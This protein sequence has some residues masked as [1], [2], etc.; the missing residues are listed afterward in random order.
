MDP[1]ANLQEQESILVYHARAI[2][3]GA[4]VSAVGDSD[5]ARLAELRADLRAWLDG[6]GFEPDWA[7]CP[8]AS[9][10]FGH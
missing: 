3:S 2:E 9:R 10:Y 1:N 4:G 8:R 6:G 7:A 5:R